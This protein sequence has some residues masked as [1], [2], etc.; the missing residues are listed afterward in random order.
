M[1]REKATMEERI[2]YGN[3][4]LLNQLL[5]F[6]DNYERALQAVPQIEKEPK[7]NLEKELNQLKNQL[8]KETNLTKKAELESQKKKIEQQIQNLEIIQQKIEKILEGLQMVLTWFRNFLRKQAV[9]EI[10]VVPGKDIFDGELHEFLQ[11][12]ENNDYPAGTILQVLQ[13]GYKIR[14]RVLR[15]AAVKISKISNK[16]KEIEK[17]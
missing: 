4:K 14:N 8:Q 9:E 5:F 12:E 16:T 10:E 3:E 11:E 13:K 6:P 1:E 2:K 15:P 7:Q 17:K